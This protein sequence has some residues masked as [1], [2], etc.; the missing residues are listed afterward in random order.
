M[1]PLLFA[2]LALTTV[3]AI[4]PVRV[5]TDSIWTIPTA[6]SLVRD[7]DTDLSEYGAAVATTPHGLET[8]AAGSV[9][10]TFPV[11]PALVAA[12]FLWVA[13]QFA[14]LGQELPAPLSRPFTRWRTGIEPNPGV[15]L[16]FFDTTEVLIASA[17][18]AAGI[19]AFFIVCRAYAG[20][21]VALVVTIVLAFGSPSLS[22]WTR[23]LWSHGPAFA[24]LAAAAA[25]LC[26]GRLR[27]ATLFLVGALAVF[28]VVCRPT[29][30]LPGGVLCAAAIAGAVE[31]RRPLEAIAALLGAVAVAAPWLGWSQ[32]TWGRLLPP[33]YAVTRLEASF[34]DGLAA[35]AGQLLSP[36][37]GLFIYI[38]FLLLTFAIPWVRS[39]MR[40][41]HVIALVLGAAHLLVA[42]RFPHWWGGHCY[43]PRLS[44][45]AVPF[46]L[47]A[48]LPV[49]T[50]LAEAR[51]GRW[52]LGSLVALC[53]FAN[54]PGAFRWS[55]WDWSGSPVDVDLEPARL[56]DWR[57]PQF[58]R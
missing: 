51:A 45:D 24:S 37:R 13:N 31:R 21:R 30:M 55:T 7:G 10:S 50:P 58:M 49:V 2:W 33:Y 36:S 44:S 11:G 5:Q 35:L 28:A 54:A 43:G 34:A 32:A 48:C 47:F 56:W 38:P 17:L 52:L 19:I 40:R 15:R 1:R 53:L 39:R 22:T 25:V 14:L 29:A 3:Y 8:T 12:P 26:A 18:V 4:A 23:A 6:L 46:L 42:S 27:P 57:D 9:H 20:P 16:G 41:V